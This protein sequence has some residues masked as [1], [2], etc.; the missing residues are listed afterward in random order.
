MEWAFWKPPAARQG[1][2]QSQAEGKCHVVNSG[3]SVP[4]RSALNLGTPG[5]STWAL[6]ASTGMHRRGTEAEGQEL[7]PGCPLSQQLQHAPHPYCPVSGR[8]ASRRLGAAA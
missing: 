4:L 2:W 3:C 7:T 6:R 1:G 5:K 8:V